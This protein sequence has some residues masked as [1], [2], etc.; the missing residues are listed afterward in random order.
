MNRLLLL[1]L[2]LVLFSAL[3]AQNTPSSNIKGMVK[4]SATAKAVNG[5]NLALSASEKILVSATTGG[6]GA[7]VLKAVP[8]GT[9][10]LTVS[11]V[12]YRSKIVPLTVGTDAK[13]I[14]LST[15]SLSPEG[16]QLAG[17]TVTAQK[18]L[19]EDKGDRL[20]YNADKDPSNVSGTAADVMRKV[21][22]LTVDLNGNVQMRGSSNIKVLVNGKPSAMMA[23]NL[24]DALKQM[25][26]HLVKS[27]EVITSPGAKYDAEGAAG[28]INIITKKGLKGF[29]GSVNTTAGNRNRSL[30]S[31]LNWRT[32]KLGLSFSGTGYQYDNTNEGSG[33]RTT[34]K[35]GQ[36]L[37][38]L[39][40]NTFSDNTGTGGYGELALD[41]DPDSSRHLSLAM[42]V[43]GGNYP[44]NST[45]FNHLADVSGNVLQDFRT[46]SRFKNPYG[47]GQVDVGYTKTYKPDKEFALLAQF[48]RMPDNYFY[49][50]EIY[51]G[52]QVTYR[53]KSTN[54][55]S[56][57]QYT[58][59]AD[60]SLPLLRNSRR[61]TT[62][63]K[64]EMGTKAI[65]RDIGSDYHVEHSPDGQSPMVT[66][67]TQ[68][69][70]FDYTQHV[71][72]AYSSLRL[73]NKRKWTLVAGARLEHTQIRGDFISTGT[74]L[75]D[76]YNNLIPSV[77]LSKG[78]DKHTLKASYTQ[79][80][81]RPM[82]WYLNPWVNQSDPKN[83]ST[84][85]PDLMPELNHAT[86]LSHSFSGKNGFNLNTALFWRT[87][88]NA[89][90][91]VTR[92]D[93]L[94]TSLSR[95]ENLAR[96]SNYGINT[97]LSMQPNKNWNVNGGV[98]LNY[99]DLY[100]PALQQGNSGWVWNGN[101]N[102]TY[103]LP[104]EIMLQGY[105]SISSGWISLQ[106]NAQSL[107]YWYGFSAKYTFL[108][109]K[110]DL[111]LGANNPFAR[112]VQQKSEEFGPTFLAT[113]DNMFV[114]RSFSLTF[115]WRFGQLNA[116]GGKK[117]RK[118]SNDDAGR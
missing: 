44:F 5:A 94:G 23:R 30:G 40:R 34:L 92:V 82:I 53:Q 77:T 70:V 28:M 12:G 62:T 99:V 52:D 43:W 20:V 105:G 18:A 49:T 36:P 41:Y 106:R 80:I 104:K 115:Q 10:T 13:D 116:D 25:P 108:E 16:Q 2:S 101:M 89:L 68:T 56:N 17:V 103:K 73:S 15:L 9:Y 7:F 31:S 47:N 39:R 86:E 19:V 109:K 50:S 26:A 4:D 65:I 74:S 95:P 58:L 118:I 57:L 24:A 1:A 110:A 97:N 38:I 14:D 42:N 35:N 8:P 112:G 87:T 66:D 22:S 48:S 96:R 71:Y 54:Y 85:N 81:T 60:Y 32:G 75:D 76:G 100:S 64:V 93:S 79:R 46:E 37:N 6:D 11:Y 29:N 63:G 61:D 84:G 113:F 78:I 3:K 91:Y 27:V 72:S 45:A 114:S 98:H 33:V 69:N 117:G 111:T 21:P 107:W 55:S 90:E 67:P 83:L 51:T 59:Q 88:N 102:M